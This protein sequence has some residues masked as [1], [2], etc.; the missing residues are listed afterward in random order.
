MLLSAL[1]DAGD[2]ALLG[3]RWPRLPGVLLSSVVGFL[4]SLTSLL[5][6]ALARSLGMR[7]GD[8]WRVLVPIGVAVPGA[9]DHGGL[10]GAIDTID[11]TTIDLRLPTED[12]KGAMVGAVSPSAANPFV[13]LSELPPI[14][15][16]VTG[17]QNVN[18]AG[19]GVFEAKAGAD[20][21]FRGI[22]GTGALLVSL[23]AP[24]SEIELSLSPGL[25]S[26]QTLAGAGTLTHAQI[27]AQTPTTA[28]KA[29]LTNAAS[30]SAS[31]PF[32]TVDDISFLAA[33]GANINT[34][35]IGV[36]DGQSG[37]TLQFRGIAS[38]NSAL[39]IQLFAPANEIRV[40][41]LP[42]QIAHGALADSGVIDH[43]SIDLL[44]PDTDEKAAMQGAN[45]PQAGNPFATFDD[46][47]T[48]TLAEG[49]N[50]NNTGIGV[51]HGQNG[52]ALG[53]RGVEGTG[54]ITAS[55][56][57]SDATIELGLTLSAIDHDSLA[58]TGLNTHG[59]IDN[60]IADGAIH[61][62][63]S[64]TTPSPVSSVLA[65]TGGLETAARAD[66]T[67]EVLTGAPVAIGAGNFSGSLAALSRA[68][69]SHAIR[70]TSGP[71]LVCAELHFRYKRP[72]V[73]RERPDEP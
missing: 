51:F 28:Q 9:I 56:N 47:P 46:L 49:Q 50:V 67:H 60:H 2:G 10:L 66:H 14:P 68:D 6:S 69:H 70:E 11:H 40:G 63:L 52:N 8:G 45:A 65:L 42:G 72:G 55:L 22:V 27:D 73:S 15:G 39:S 61:Y 20:L 17:G 18:A 48:V 5:G 4:I 64:T 12:E 38:D 1:A 30:P 13:T 24:N 36:F 29:A 19:V 44:L 23:D 34:A 71:H 35:G 7:I 54:A 32:A 26:H 16:D 57:P 53:F 37:N 25:I 3:V 43:T 21:T 31:N 41:L 33:T 58:G 59:A 62:N